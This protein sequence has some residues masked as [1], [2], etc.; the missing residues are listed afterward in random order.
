MPCYDSRD[1][2]TYAVEEARKT[3]RHNSDVADMLC[4]LLKKQT[5]EY[6][7]TLP[8]ATQVWWKE[9]Q[10]RDAGKS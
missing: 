3:F 9:H 4:N 2:S 10:E 7:A 6:I 8:V 5:P 1:S